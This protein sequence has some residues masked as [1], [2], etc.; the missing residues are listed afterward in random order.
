MISGSFVNGIIKYGIENMKTKSQNNFLFF[1]SFFWRVDKFHQITNW[2]WFQLSHGVIIWTKHKKNH[3]EIRKHQKI[4]LTFQINNTTQHFKVYRLVIDKEN[5]S[6]C[7]F[8]LVKSN[9]NWMSIAILIWNQMIY[10]DFIVIDN[11]GVIEVLKLNQ[12]ENGW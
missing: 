1:F 8:T 2:W 11:L 4:I 12:I 5:P 6:N 3:I 10:V 9:A 7:F